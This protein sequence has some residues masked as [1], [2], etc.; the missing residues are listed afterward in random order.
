[1][2]RKLLLVVLLISA[3]GLGCGSFGDDLCALGGSFIDDPACPGV[4]AQLALPSHR[5]AA[6]K[7]VVHLLAVLPAITTLEPLHVL[8]VLP[9]AE[10]APAPSNPVPIRC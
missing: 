7:A 4:T 3:I 10:V 5:Q 1:M 8:P 6:P 9:V 2:H